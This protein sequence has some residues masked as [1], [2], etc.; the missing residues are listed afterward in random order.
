MTQ[1]NEQREL[2]S[3][4]MFKVCGTKEEIDRI[5]EICANR[6]D[7]K[8]LELPG[9][10]NDTPIITFAEIEEQIKKYPCPPES[11]SE[12]IVI[13]SLMTLTGGD[14]V[15]NTR[16]M[17]VVLPAIPA[18]QETPKYKNDKK[19]RHE[20]KAQENLV[21]LHNSDKIKERLRR[22]LLKKQSQ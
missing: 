3:T 13:G 14:E 18:I 7:M 17:E 16:A 1:D 9:T 22:K 19:L 15:I 10:F 2:S 6:N 5:R 12:N 11:Q 8:V 4:S 21:D 20:L